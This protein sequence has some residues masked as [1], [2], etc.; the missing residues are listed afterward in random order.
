MSLLPAKAQE[1][2][3]SG[4]GPSFSG[5]DYSALAPDVAADAKAIAQR[6]LAG[7]QRQIDSILEMG[8]DLS[9][10]KQHLGHG[11]FG[12]WLAAEVGFSERTAQNYMSAWAV[13]GDQSA[14]VSYLKQPTDLYALASA[15]E[16]VRRG[17]LDRLN[18][19]E[20]SDEIN[21]P[22][23]IAEAKAD[24]RAQLISARLSPAEKRK[25]QTNKDREA[26]AR[27]K[28]RAEADE[29]HKAR[30]AAI[31][32]AAR[33]IAERFG[34]DLPALAALLKQTWHSDLVQAIERCAARCS[35]EA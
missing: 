9:T 29:K 31:E 23:A 7:K 26:R 5:Y 8:K 6:I 11:N 19:G 10:A 27:D 4:E 34:D 16:T 12:K 3:W 25:R 13:F 18:K 35:Q 28:A 21:I 17:I 1:I 30:V 22:R 32:K 33:M 15:T 20:R 2:V 14:T 24:Q